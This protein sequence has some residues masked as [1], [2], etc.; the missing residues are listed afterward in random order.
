MAKAPSCESSPDLSSHFSAMSLEERELKAR[1]EIE[2]ME[3]EEY[4]VDLE[5]KRDTMKR[6]HEERLQ[7]AR[8]DSAIQRR[9]GAR[10][11]RLQT[12]KVEMKVDDSTPP[13]NNIRMQ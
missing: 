6:R 2:A 5:A 13:S 1:K 12:L 10:T 7:C 4:V 3:L 11:L 8:Y 9:G